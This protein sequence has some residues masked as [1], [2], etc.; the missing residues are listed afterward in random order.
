MFMTRIELDLKRRETQRA[1]NNP[2][3]F[4]HAIENCFSGPRQRR[5]WRLDSF[6]EKNYLIIVS[7]NSP[8]LSKSFTEFAPQKNNNLCESKSYISFMHR[9]K[10]GQKWHFR[11]SANPV[12]AAVDEDIPKGTRGKVRAHVTPKQQIQWLSDRAESIGV[13]FEVN[14]LQVVDSNWYRFY[15]RSGVCV[16][17]RKVTFEGLLT[18]QDPEILKQNLAEGIGRQK[19]YGCGLLTLALPIPK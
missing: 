9:L 13:H 19:A 11:L 1:L 3:Y 14:T 10:E 8:D 15:K 18:V 17:F 5:L 2:N 16:T 4:H 12:K 7:E 6:G